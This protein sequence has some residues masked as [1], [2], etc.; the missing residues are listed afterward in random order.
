MAINL[1]KSWI[2]LFLNFEDIYNLKN[3]FCFF[4][5]RNWN[6][7]INNKK[8]VIVD[9]VNYIRDKYNINDIVVFL[10]FD[11]E[12]KKN[13]IENSIL[14]ELNINR[15]YHLNSKSTD[16]LQLVDILL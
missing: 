2:N 7:K 15:V 11:T 12:H 9:F 8:E 6:K 1:Y 14:K 16:M 5:K 4:E 10:D 3:E 13:N